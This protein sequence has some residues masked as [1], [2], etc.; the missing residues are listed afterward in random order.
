[1]QEK[2][3]AEILK[4][5]DRLVQIRKSLHANPELSDVEE[6]TSAFI[7]GILESLGISVKRNVGGYGV[8]G[9]LRGKKGGKTIAMRAD[10]DALPI[11]EKRDSDYRSKNSGVMH[12]CGHDMHMAVLIGAAMVLSTLTGK[13]TGCI[14]FIFQPCEE[15]VCGAK[16]MMDEGALKN[17]KVDAMIGLHVLPSLKTGEIGVRYGTMMASADKVKI[18]IKGRSGHAA[19]PHESIDAILVASVVITAIHHIV[20]RQVDPLMPAIISLGMINGGTAPNIIANRVE[21]FGTVRSLT[22]EL[23]LSLAKKIEK[24]IKGVTAGM[25]ADYEYSFTKGPPPLINDDDMT[26]L[27]EKSAGSIIGS[28]NV[29][30]IDKPTMGGEDFALYLKK[31]PG[32]F[33]RLGTGSEE[34][35]TCH[36]LHNEMFDVD[37]DAIPTGVSVM[38]LSALN[39]LKESV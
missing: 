4:I 13:F 12:A 39:F 1:M 2:I 5:N 14:R 34:K 25:G 36:P 16:G 8:V 30:T 26:R 19:Q 33:F 24:V 31:V 35:D 38:V 21:I 20:S 23:R 18:V 28:E 9:T 22:E 7:A 3:K 27:V 6:E 11:T 29:V 32:V 10:I 37:D 15:K 17:P